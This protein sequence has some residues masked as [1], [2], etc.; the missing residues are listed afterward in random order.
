MEE[1]NIGAFICS[2]RKE[3]NMTQKQLAQQLGITD[4]AVSKWERGPKLKIPYSILL[5]HACLYSHIICLSKIL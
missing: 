1:K 5:T 2:L 4:K 3:K